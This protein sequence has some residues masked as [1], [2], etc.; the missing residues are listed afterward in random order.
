MVKKINLNNST[1]PWVA[2]MVDG[3]WGFV[4][5][6]TG[7]LIPAIYDSVWSFSNGFARVKVDNKVGVI[8]SDGSFLIEPIFDAIWPF[9]NGIAKVNIGGALVNGR[10]F[11]GKYGYIKTNGSYLTEVIFDRGNEFKSN[12]VEVINGGELNKDG[13]YNSGGK[14]GIIDMDGKITWLN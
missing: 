4:N 3:K 13:S 11:G 10:F 7:G 5:S 12:F 8:K 14:K 6:V 9:H 2:G 1:D